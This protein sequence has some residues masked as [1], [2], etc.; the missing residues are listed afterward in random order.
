MKIVRYARLAVDLIVVL[1]LIAL[2]A[3][4]VGCAKPAAHSVSP[5]RS[6][7]LEAWVEHPP[8]PVQVEPCPAPEPVTTPPTEPAAD[9]SWGEPP[10]NPHCYEH[11]RAALVVAAMGQVADRPETSAEAGQPGVTVKPDGTVIL[12]PGGHVRMAESEGSGLSTTADELA[13]NWR[14]DAPTAQ[15][16]GLA[17]SGGGLRHVMEATGIKSQPGAVL[18]VIGGL[19]LAA[20]VVAFFMVNRK[21]GTA[22]AAAGGAVLL[23][24]WLVGNPVAMFALCGVGLLAVV[25]AVLWYGRTARADAIA[26][27]AVTTSVKKAANGSAGAIKESVK[28]AAGVQRPV[29]DKA[30]TRALLR[31]GERP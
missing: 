26:L 4:A 24:A 29:V 2:G 3:L 21:L 13:A 9:V 22:I 23:A 14:T 7:V 27:S 28:T 30:I 25:G 10:P 15:S 8:V 16:P 31:A 18:F 19:I 6:S 12:G 1:V 11:I 17:A 20:G 5:A